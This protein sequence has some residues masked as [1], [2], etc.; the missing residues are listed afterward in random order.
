MMKYKVV[1]ML[2]VFAF[3]PCLSTAQATAS[4]KKSQNDIKQEREESIDKKEFPQT[5]LPFIEELN[6]DNKRV[7]YYRE[8]DGDAYS[9]EA[10]FKNNRREYNIE[11]Y[12][13]GKIQ[14]VEVTVRRRTI[15]NA[16]WNKIENHFKAESKR[17]KVTKIQ[18]QYIYSDDILKRIATGLN[19]NFEI[20]VSFKSKR[21]IYR[22]EYLISASGDIVKIRDVKRQEYDFILF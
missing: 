11:C 9:Y 13:S 17:F 3:V 8:T 21:K 12:P 10:K 19:D 18:R 22:K 1:V 2:M 6:V 5:A 4:P 20:S 14:D 15:D 7:R 16:I